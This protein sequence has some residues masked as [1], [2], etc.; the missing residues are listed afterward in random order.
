MTL[1]YGLNILMITSAFQISVAF[2]RFNNPI[3]LVKRCILNESRTYGY[4]QT[5]WK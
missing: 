3:Y 1:F 4:S 5:Q 2:D